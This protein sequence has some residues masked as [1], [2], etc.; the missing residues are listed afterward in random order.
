MEINGQL[1]PEIEQIPLPPSLQTAIPRRQL[2]FRAGRYCAM[3]AMSALDAS[4]S[5][6]QVERSAAGAPMWP[7]GIV[8]SI[9]HCRDLAVA[10]VAST[11]HVR[12]IGIDVEGVISESEARN[13]N[14]IVAWPAEV[15]HGRGAG[16]TRLE[17]LTLV[18]SAKES[19]FKC[20]HPIVGSYFD[21]HDVRIV[22]VDPVS[23]TFAARVVRTLG[24][25]VAA[26]SVLD[27]RFRME[28]QLIHTGVALEPGEVVRTTLA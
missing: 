22:A 1:P 13:I 12:A 26:K 8:G 16:L 11:A 18:F 2:E 19:I 25:V 20:L 21:F 6:C 10:A 4:L 15:A 27:G 3:R 28:T 7:E 9:A 24:D 23:G 14:R 5:G 17:A